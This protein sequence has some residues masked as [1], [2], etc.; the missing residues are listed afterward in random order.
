[1]AGKIVIDYQHDRQVVR[2]TLNAPK[3]NV[4]DSEMMGE[5]QTALDSLRDEPQ[6]K[7]IQFTGAGSHFSFGASVSEHVRQQASEM[8][9]QFHGIFRSVVHL[10]IPTAALVSGQCLGGGLELALMCNFLFVDQSAQLGQPEIKL[11]VFAPPAS[12]I[13]PLKVGQARADDLLLTGRSIKA[14]EAVTIGL[15]AQMFATRE[16]LLDGVDRWVREHIL[17]KSASSLRIAVR[18]AR[19]AFNDALLDRLKQLEQLYLDELM[20]THDAN[21]GIASFLERRDP[22]WKNQ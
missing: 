10:A 16:S 17:P 19:H 4:L 22:V 20:T 14:D 8:L 21:E 3:A 2:L 9:R 1:M 7:L 5:L 12:L 11:A 18:A 15:A 13:L 6:V